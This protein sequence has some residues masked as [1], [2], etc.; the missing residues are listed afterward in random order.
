[1]YDTAS[2]VSR[3]VCG[4]GVVKLFIYTLI[5]SG[6]TVAKLKSA[7]CLRPHSS[8]DSLLC[9][10]SRENLSSGFRIEPACS[11]TETS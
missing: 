8:N 4:E 2:D 3:Y 5:I 11:G 1:M 7:R 9:A 10:T 6:Q